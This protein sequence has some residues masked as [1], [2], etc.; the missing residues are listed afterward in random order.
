MGE[1]RS[2]FTLRE[3]EGF[4]RLRFTMPD[5]SK[6][7]PGYTDRLGRRVVVVTSS[8]GLVRFFDGEQ[9]SPQKYHAI[10]AAYRRLGAIE[11]TT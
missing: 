11:E 2:T 6:P 4:P 5:G 10:A 7:F 1:P 9:L 8:T 3:P